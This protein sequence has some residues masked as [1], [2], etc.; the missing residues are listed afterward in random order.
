MNSNKDNNSRRKFLGAL[1]LGAT[2][3]TISMLA[4][5]IFAKMPSFDN[6]K[7]SGLD[8]WFKSGIKGK[9]RIVYDG[10]MPHFGLPVLWNYAFYATNNATGASDDDI[11]AMTVFRHRAIPFAFE[12]RLWKKYKLGE[13]FNITD[14]Y[15]NKPATHNLYNEPRDK[16]FPVAGVDGIKKLQARGAMFCVCDLA[17]KVYGGKLAE[18]YGLDA[19]EVYNDLTSG[20]LPGVKLVP[21]GVWALGRAQDNGCGYIFAGE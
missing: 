15:T 1:A 16:D 21:S 2:A 19:T 7:I 3:S 8:S 12:D 20:L 9:Y 10:S 14:N 11:T 5:P 18:K 13:F 17:A 6:S 4:N